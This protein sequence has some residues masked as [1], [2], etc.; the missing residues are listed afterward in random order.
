M[1]FRKSYPFP[2]CD[3][4]RENIT[5]NVQVYLTHGQDEKHADHIMNYVK[6]GGGLII[7]GHVSWPNQSTKNSNCYMSDFPGNV[8]I[9]R[10]GV[11]FSQVR[12]HEKVAAMCQVD[13]VPA[14]RYSLYYNLKHLAS[15][16]AS[17]FEENDIGK[18]HRAYIKEIEKFQDVLQSHDFFDIIFEIWKNW[19]PVS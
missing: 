6:N 4:T 5:S 11:V 16:S 14:L 8:L 13:R 12:V 18:L 2:K 19:S 15:R 17:S 3:V 10:T 7:G 1:A 9:A